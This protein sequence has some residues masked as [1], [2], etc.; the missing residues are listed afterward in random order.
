MTKAEKDYYAILGV[1]EKADADAIKKAY[2]RLAKQYHPDANPGDPRAAERFKEVGEANGVLSDPRKR[3]KYDQMRK[4]GAFGFGGPR[5][6]PRPEST[7]TPG[8]SF[9]D[10]GG[11]GGILGDLLVHLRP[12]PEGAACASLGSP[13]GRAPRAGHRRALHDGGQGGEGPRF[14]FHPRGMRHLCRQG[15]SPGDGLEEVRRVQGI[16]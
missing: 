16:G 4:L 13:Q 14:G 3:K 8:F 7:S 15:W 1:D 11:L 5:G 10:L 6:G 12:W 2:R 9:E